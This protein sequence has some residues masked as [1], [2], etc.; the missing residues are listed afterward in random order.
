MARKLQHQVHR[1]PRRRDDAHVHSD[2]CVARPPEGPALGNFIRLVMD[3]T[4]CDHRRATQV[5]AAV[6]SYNT[7]D[8]LG[9]CLNSLT[10]E[11]LAAVIVV[12]NASSDGSVEFVASRYPHATVIAN[13]SNRGYAAAANQALAMA[14]SPYVLL[15]NADTVVHAGA[16]AQLA[17]Y[18]EGHPT[19]AIAGPAIL[20][21]NGAV[22]PSCFPFPGTH[23]WFW[24]NAPLSYW[25][26]RVPFAR[27]RSIS[28]RRASS[29]R[30]V[31]WVL[32]A[33][34][35]LRRRAVLDAGGMD[36][37][38]FLYYEEVDL[39]RRLA[40]TAWETHYVPS[41]VIAH[42]GAASTSQQRS[43]ALVRRF[44]STLQYYDRHL[45]GPARR[46]WRTLVRTKWAA[47]LIRD[48]AHLLILRDSARR[49]EVR[50]QWRAYSAMTFARRP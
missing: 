28:W 47:L 13:E 37:T 18:L 10:R 7:R 36:E 22:Q 19:A 35:L 33:A 16:V 45:T 24:E 2:P 5:T 48:S 8:Y 29:P 21:E 4:G 31:P 34:M 49:E 25:T 20:D 3:R 23:G 14:T 17:A 40:A 41:A 9:R 32:G 39:C 1:W 43:A 27:E 6:V 50:A 15:L 42:V 12:D 11:P 30:A 46:L 38:Y 44:Q 26:R